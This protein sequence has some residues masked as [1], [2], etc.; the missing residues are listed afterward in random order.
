MDEELLEALDSCLT[1]ARE[2]SNVLPDSQSGQGVDSALMARRQWVERQ[3]ATMIAKLKAM[4]EDL[5]VGLSAKEMGFE[6]PQEL[7]DLVNDIRAQI[8]HLKVMC[9][10]LS[11]GLGHCL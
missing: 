5:A 6:D 9:L 8:V 11:K 3:L 4:Q 10:A 7:L 2:V 1:A